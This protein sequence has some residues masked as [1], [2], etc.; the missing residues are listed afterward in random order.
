M[1]KL[2]KKTRNRFFIVEKSSNNVVF[3]Y[4][5]KNDALKK[6]NFL[7]KGNAFNGMIPNFMF[8]GTI[9]PGTENYK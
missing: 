1:Y 8:N 6:L 5:N 9:K 2:L 4:P 7:N 3:E